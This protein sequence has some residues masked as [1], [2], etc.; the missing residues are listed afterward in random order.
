[1]HLEKVL[2]TKTLPARVTLNEFTPSDGGRVGGSPSLGTLHGSAAQPISSHRTALDVA[3]HSARKS[4]PSIAP[5]P[6]A[7]NNTPEFYQSIEPRSH[8]P[9]QQPKSL[10]RQRSLSPAPPG[11]AVLP[12]HPLSEPIFERSESG[13]SI[14]RTKKY[15]RL[16]PRYALRD[17]RSEG[18]DNFVA[19]KPSEATHVPLRAA[20]GVTSAPRQQN[21]LDILCDQRGETT[22]QPASYPNDFRQGA[23]VQQDRPEDKVPEYPQQSSLAHTHDSDSSSR[24]STQAT[25][26][27][28]NHPNTLPPIKTLFERRQNFSTPIGY[29]RWRWQRQYHHGRNYDNAREHS[30]VNDYGT[31]EP[32]IM[33]N[34]RFVYE[35]D[36][37]GRTLVH[38][39]SPMGPPLKP[40][41]PPTTESIALKQQ[42][43]VLRKQEAEEYPVADTYQVPLVTQDSNTLI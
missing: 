20:T 14:D 2:N 24:D 32:H 17:E 4:T 10:K 36:G 42:L 5:C 29:D 22:H 1:M 30:S 41:D 11:I 43:Y 27:H 33:E 35:P 13:E 23:Y 37:G 7:H 31:Y 16:E 39:T 40:L 34:R 38:G 3:T 18:A 9:P 25:R 26:G 6:E 28:W 12:G 21:A 15:A 19:L 8:L